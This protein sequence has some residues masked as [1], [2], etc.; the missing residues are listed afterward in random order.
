[1]SRT[2]RADAAM[3]KARQAA[4][5]VKPVAEQ[6][7]PLAES[8]KEAADRQLRKT[9]A[10]AAPQVERTGQ[11]LQDKVAPK[12]SA[13]LS[14]AADRIAPDKEPKR[15]LSLAFFAAALAATVAAAAAA[16]RSRT[17]GQRES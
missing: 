12:V 11:V 10:W 16:L 9:R 4:A 8:T 3:D 14:S 17:K 13:M 1:M 7:R 6:L 2:S 5:Q 15:R